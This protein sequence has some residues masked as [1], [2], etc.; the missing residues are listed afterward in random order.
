MAPTG[1]N[2]H[3]LAP[4]GTFGAL[5]FLFSSGRLAAEAAK[6]LHHSDSHLTELI[7]LN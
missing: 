2:W 5:L 1:T 7:K 4:S 3:Q 6:Y